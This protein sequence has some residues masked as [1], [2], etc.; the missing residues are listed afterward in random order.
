MISFKSLKT[1]S[2]DVVLN[3]LASLVSTGVM[4]LVLY[5]V[6]AKKMGDECYGEML[7]I[8]G[9]VNII[10]LSIG[11]NL[12]N[13]RIVVNE[14]YKKEGIVGDFQILI[15][16]GILLST[17]VILLLNVYFSW[18]FLLLI[19]LIFVTVLSVAK[20]YYLVIYRIDI[21][22][23]KNL[24]ANIFMAIGYI[25]GAF[26]LIDFLQWP[27]V[28]AFAS[29]TGLVYIG[30][31]SNIIREPIIK[32]KL[33]KSSSKVAL[34]L[35][36]S[37]IVGNVTMYL[38]RFI[39]YPILGGSSVSYYTVASFF[40]K[41]LS[42][43]LL[44]ITT[45]LLSYIAAD[46]ITI[47]RK[48]FLAINGVL[49][50]GTILFLVLSVTIGKYITGLL[51]PTIIGDSQQYILMAS[52]GVVIGIATSFNGIIVLAKA[53]SFWQVVLST[54]N[55]IVYFISC[56]ILVKAEGLYGLCYGVIITN[57]FMFIVN[58]LVGNYY[59]KRL[60]I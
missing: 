38:D 6:L 34:F 45:V 22:Y 1:I 28:F 18:S 7:T 36:V 50:L 37:G 10:V 55:L 9:I 53:P 35:L 57:V 21:N 48:R 3:L 15:G 60:S 47:T 26:I 13:A 29:L 39:V 25:I 20:S 51:Y 27:W 23:K 42:L 49:L 56:Y 54:V 43:I 12:C 4:Q 46:K 17:L 5:P 14:Q 59:I 30:I 19:G 41:S 58:Y 2:S 24:Y 33:F 40:A 52:I 32:T 31:S 44:P 8:M 16:I 11:N